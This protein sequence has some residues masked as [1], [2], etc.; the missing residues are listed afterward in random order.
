MGQKCANIEQA[1][2][3]RKYIRDLVKEFKTRV[4]KGKQVKKHLVDLIDDI[5]EACVNMKY[6]GMDFDA[7]EI[8]TTFS[9]PSFKAWRVKISGVK[10]AD[11]NDLKGANTKHSSN[12]VTSD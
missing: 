3:F 12:I 7:E 2:D 9:D 11:K 1:S 10:F 4:A 8:A 5:R 6:P